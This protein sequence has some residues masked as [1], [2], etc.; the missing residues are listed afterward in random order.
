VWTDRS[1]HRYQ[2]AR[3]NGQAR[4]QIF[5]AHDELSLVI[6]LKSEAQAIFSWLA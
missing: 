2:S 5:P 1:L 4:S 6:E 3:F